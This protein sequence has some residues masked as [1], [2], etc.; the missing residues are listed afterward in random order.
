M[1]CTPTTQPHQIG[2]SEFVELLATFRDTAFRLEAQSAYATSTAEA[3]ALAEFVAGDPQPPEAHPI[4]RAW[5]DGIRELTSHG[6]KIS[7]VRLLDDPPTDYQR[8]AMWCT[9]Y[10]VDA[11]EHIQYLSRT[12]AGRFGIPSAD[13][14]LFDDDHLVFMLFTDDGQLESMTLIT[15]PH[16]IARHCSWR[17]LA[18]E[19]ATTAHQI[20]I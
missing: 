8:W 12:D 2:E 10:H 16:V 1:T 13:W 15:A 11:G 3:E 20:L 18:I 6:K 7:R 14:W 4:W 17:A 5:L 9:R 19:H